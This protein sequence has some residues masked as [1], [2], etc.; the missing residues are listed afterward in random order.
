MFVMGS[1][2]AAPVDYQFFAVVGTRDTD[3]GEKLPPQLTPDARFRGT[4][5]FDPARTEN[6]AVAP[7]LALRLSTVDGTEVLTSQGHRLTSNIETHSVGGIESL[8]ISAEID[9]EETNRQVRI[10]FSWASPGQGQLPADPRTVDITALQPYAWKVAL[11]GD[12]LVCETGCVSF[13]ERIDGHLLGFSRAGSGANY[14]ESF[15]AAPPLWTNTGG[16]WSTQSG[17]YTNAGNVAFTSSIYNGQT[18]QPFAEVRTDLYSGFVNSGNALGVLVNYRDANN[19]REVRFTA[20]G[21]V[22]VNQ[23]TNGV[24]TMV[25]TG[26][27]SVPPQT[28]FHVSVVLD[29]GTIE[30]AVNNQQT[31]SVDG[32]H[33]PGPMLDGRAGV[34]ASWN[35]A[36]VDNFAIQ[37]LSGWNR[38]FNESFSSE[39]SLQP[40]SGTWV[41]DNGVYRNTSNQA[42]AISTLPPPSGVFDAFTDDL[43][44]YARIR[45][46]WSSSGNRGGLVYDF[47]NLQNYRAVLISAKTATRAGKVEVIEVVNGQSRVVASS[48]DTQLAAGQWGEVSVVRADGVV[49]VAVTGMSA[50]YITLRQDSRGGVVGVIGSWNLVRFD[51]LV[52]NAQSGPI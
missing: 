11:I 25:Q 38:D 31:L 10:Q 29:F 27:Y 46:T 17:Y 48:T 44:A 42:A 49:R 6:G 32:D 2:F 43:A 19:F 30:V 28:F 13:A 52:F 3:G 34:F 16:N 41:I 20:N 23:V 12:D 47:S 50:P 9:L 5:T 21:V 37:E 45:L 33:F 15:S 14:D 39:T 8:L 4:L 22:Q 36:R 35:K 26:R 7:V 24:R 18:L 40:Q 51:D 1:A